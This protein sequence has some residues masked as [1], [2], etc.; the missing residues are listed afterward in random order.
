VL[1]EEM[2]ARFYG[3]LKEPFL[4]PAGHTPSKNSTALIA[5]IAMP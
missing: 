1:G 2:I 3:G 4:L 5:V